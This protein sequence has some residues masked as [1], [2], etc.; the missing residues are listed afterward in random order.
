MTRSPSPQ[1]RR[2][3]EALGDEPQ[4]WRHGYELLRQTGLKSGSLYP[5]LVRLTERGWLE[6]SWEPDAPPGRPARH[7]YR[8]TGEGRRALAELGERAQATMR[9]RRLAR[10][11]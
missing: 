3:L 5:I 7:L 8:L 6:A 9:H 1:T 10:P 11:T 4:A 2:V